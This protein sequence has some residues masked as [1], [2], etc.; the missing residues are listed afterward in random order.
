MITTATA[1]TLTYQHVWNNGNDGKGKVME[2][3]A[4]TNA[5]HVQPPAPPPAPP[6]PKPP[7]PAPSPP[8]PTPAPTP[9][10]Y[11]WKCFADQ[12]CGSV[13]GLEDRDYVNDEPTYSECEGTCNALAGCVALRYHAEDKH[14]HVLIGPRPTL[15]S[16]QK[17]LK[18]APLY[19]SCLQVK[20]P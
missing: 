3:W 9:A 18:A 8:K 14:C 4:I 6:A 1:D 16:F 11:S 2:T 20:N 12:S 19:H 7:A 10:G 5:T 15:A 13:A 17:D